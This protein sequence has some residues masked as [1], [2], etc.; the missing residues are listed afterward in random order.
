MRPRLD[1]RE[2]RQRSVA[3]REGLSDEDCAAQAMPDASPLKWHLAHTTWFF[4]TF[5][6]SRYEQGFK[7]FNPE[8]RSLFNSYYQAIGSQYPRSQR[9]MLT[10]PSMR[11][12]LAWREQVDER[13]LALSDKDTQLKTLIELGL[14]H[15]QQHQE[16]IVTD[17]LALMALNPLKPSVLPGVTKSC[18][19]KASA[20]INFENGLQRIGQGSAKSSKPDSD[21]LPVEFGF[22]NERPEH[23]VWLQAYTL[24]SSLVSNGEYLQFIQAGGYRDPQYWLAE[25]WDWVQ[26]LQ[27]RM[28]RQHPLYWRSATP[29]QWREYTL[30]GEHDL[31]L[32]QPLS[33]ISL[34]EADAYARWAGA[35]LPTEFEWEH[36]ARSRGTEFNDL[37]GECWQ[38]T[39]SSYA[40]Y[41]GFRTAAGAIGEYNGKFMVNQYV[42]RGSS[43]WTPAGHARISYRNF[44]PASTCW[45][46][47]GLR[48]ARD[49]Q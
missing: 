11:E 17:L 38:W 12:V 14:Q 3:L 8:F 47:S 15:E 18:M 2:I 48:L 39:S 35:R 45:Q 26:N 21:A 43:P 41:P 19:G 6:L 13:V 31:L 25:G 4:E 24:A 49:L 37:F 44:F 20:W 32:K 27:Q 42:L 23:P 33:H 28:P 36:A 34:Y 22:D 9:G 16:L 46:R 10:R 1:Y 5:V 30:Q 29:A 7:L 40:P